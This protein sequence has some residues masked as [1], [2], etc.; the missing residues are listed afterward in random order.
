MNSDYSLLN[1]RIYL[2]R[3]G[4]QTYDTPIYRIYFF[5]KRIL[6]CNKM[7]NKEKVKDFFNL[8]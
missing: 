1:L 4:K 2:G 8:H 5:K 6:K 3:T 7:N